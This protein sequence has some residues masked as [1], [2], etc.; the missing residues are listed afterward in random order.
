MGW[1]DTDAGKEY[2]KKYYEK[3]RTKLL[4][5]RREYAKE[6]RDE[7]NERRRRHYQ[8]VEKLSEE[9]MKKRNAD[10]MKYYYQQQGKEMPEESPNYAVTKEEWLERY[11]Y[12]M[13]DTTGW[14][15]WLGWDNRVRRGE[16]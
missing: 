2:S 7:I 4:E 11:G 3:N 9:R 10:R 1:R 5:A 16:E 8:E 6:H 14:E 12:P 13:G 15:H